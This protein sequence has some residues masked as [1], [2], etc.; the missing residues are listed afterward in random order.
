LASAVSAL[1]FLAQRS[2]RCALCIIR[3]R[4]I[5]LTCFTL[6]RAGDQEHRGKQIERAASALTGTWSVAADG[7]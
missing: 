4:H 6:P 5:L 3:P 1:L 7:W 2:S